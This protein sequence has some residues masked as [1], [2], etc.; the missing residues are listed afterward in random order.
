MEYI[1]GTYSEFP[2]FI[3][4]ILLR[5]LKDLGVQDVE[6]ESFNSAKFEIMCRKARMAS[7][8][9]RLESLTEEVTLE[10]YR[11]FS[12]CF[13]TTQAYENAVDLR[14]CPNPNAN[15]RVTRVFC[16]VKAR[17]HRRFLSPQLNA[18]FVALKLQLQNRTCKPLRDFGAI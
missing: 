18:I 6:S 9:F 14:V 1:L 17:L 5:L 8:S 11:S 16:S 15:L 13:S 2:S 3:S 4:L 10:I 7:S 12:L